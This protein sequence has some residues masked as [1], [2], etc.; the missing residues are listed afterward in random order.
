MNCPICEQRKSRRFCPARGESICSVCCGTEREVTIDCPPDCVHL[1][2][3]RRYEAR[4][5]LRK[6]ENLPFGEVRIP[7][8]FLSTHHEL[9]LALSH[10]ICAF[11]RDHRELTDTDAIAALESLAT[12]YQ[13][14][15]GGVYYEK[16][17]IRPLQR[18]LYDALKEEI[19]RFDRAQ[20]QSGSLGGVRNAEVRDLLIVLTQAGAAHHNGRPLCRAY[21]DLLRSQFKASEFGPSASELIVIP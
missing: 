16:P 4:M 11:A 19:Q 10:A 8:S 2:E 1:K 20:Q 6:P 14:L 5:P 18:G 9:I 21:L 17:P 3:S 7:S 15:S 13:T 12:S